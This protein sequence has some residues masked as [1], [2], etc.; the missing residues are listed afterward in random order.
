MYNTHS[1]L[2][3]GTGAGETRSASFEV[4]AWTSSCVRQEQLVLTPLDASASVGALTRIKQAVSMASALNGTSE[5]AD[6]ASSRFS[7]P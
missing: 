1:S 6:R 4:S 2:S 7:T 5:E 3:A